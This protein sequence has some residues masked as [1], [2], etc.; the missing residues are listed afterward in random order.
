MFLNHVG[1]FSIR[2]NNRDFLNSLHYSS[3]IL[4]DPKNIVIIY[5]T[6]VLLSQ[7]QQTLHFQKGINLIV[8]ENS[9]HFA[10]VFAAFL[11]D[12]FGFRRPEVRIYFEKYS[13]ER[14]TEAL[15]KAY[16]SFYQSCV[17][18]QTE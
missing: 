9:D 5:P 3:E 10:I 6:G 15:E 13:G 12:Y 7:H 17:I 1:V 4:C 18:Q 11:V 8:K 14:T 2:K 16:H